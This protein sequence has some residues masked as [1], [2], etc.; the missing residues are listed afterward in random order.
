MDAIA[1]HKIIGFQWLNQKV[2]S[3][4]NSFIEVDLTLSAYLLLFNWQQN[5]IIFLCSFIMT[6]A[7]TVYLQ[8]YLFRKDAMYMSSTF[9]NI[10]L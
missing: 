1:G 6:L 10:L 8:N 4:F 5:I 2:L 9:H 3:S 7:Y